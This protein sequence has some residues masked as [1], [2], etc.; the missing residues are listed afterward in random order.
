[1]DYKE[2]VNLIAR[3]NVPDTIKESIG[4]MIEKLAIL[5]YKARGEL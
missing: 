5:F 3:E 2:V 1:M 4:G